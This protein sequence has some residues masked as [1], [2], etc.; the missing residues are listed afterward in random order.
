MVPK[1]EAEELDE[2]KEYYSR[3]LK[4]PNGRGEDQSASDH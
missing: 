3:E 4:L 1:V 2:E